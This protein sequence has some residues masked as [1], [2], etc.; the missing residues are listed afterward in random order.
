LRQRF[1]VRGSDKPRPH[2]PNMT[3][4]FSVDKVIDDAVFILE[5]IDVRW[6]TK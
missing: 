6:S 5:K 2:K 1:S 3:K 4:G